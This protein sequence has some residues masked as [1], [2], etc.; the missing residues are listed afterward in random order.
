[1]LA[2]P[3]DRQLE[4]MVHRGRFVGGH[5]NRLEELDFLPLLIEVPKA[6]L[7]DGFGLETRPPLARQT[8][9]ES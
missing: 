9:L 3:I 1:V 5:R 6:D 2:D 8:T 4:G 7:G